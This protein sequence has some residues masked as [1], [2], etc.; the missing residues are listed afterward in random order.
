MIMIQ[1]DKYKVT[2]SR[3]NQSTLSTTTIQWQEEIIVFG[4]DVSTPEGENWQAFIF[5]MDD[6]SNAPS[7]S[8]SETINR[9]F[10][11][12][13]RGQYK[14]CLDLLRN[15]K[16][17]YIAYNEN[18]PNSSGIITDKEPAGEGE[19]ICCGS[20]NSGE[21]P[22][23]DDDRPQA[24]PR[25]VYDNLQLNDSGHRWENSYL[26]GIASL[27]VYGDWMLDNNA[28]DEFEAALRDR[29]APLVRP[30]MNLKLI[31]D[32]GIIKLNTGL[33]AMVVSNDE[34][35]ILAFRGTQ[36]NAHDW[37][38]NFTKLAA[39][40]PIIWAP[41]GAMTHPGF[42]GSINSKYEE[43]IDAIRDQRSDSSQPLLI[44]GH[45]LGGALAII[46]A[47]R[48][49]IMNDHKVG[50]VYTYGCP[51][52][53]WGTFVNVYDEAG[54]G[55]LTQRWVNHRDWAPGLP[56]PGYGHVGI[57]NYIGADGIATLG[58]QPTPFLVPE[59]SDHDLIGYLNLI[60]NNMPNNL[61]NL[62]PSLVG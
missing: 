19:Q 54:L 44:T 15:E 42:L 38:L 33:Q 31:S 50:N 60:R 55:S 62:I 11:F 9:V 12:L 18:S 48:L 2:I 13:P 27:F 21:Q 6:L 56:L 51:P 59:F 4:K 47:L 26:L 29:F 34:F 5:F 40:T 3:K 49:M 25:Y 46:M 43:I 7:N 24:T 17:V 45:S 53:S 58:M 35:I 8:K 14:K 52:L 22:G 41:I 39:P 16:P 28:G 32:D 30:P 37:T 23:S 1:A 57:P 61:Q 20:V 10:I 36:L